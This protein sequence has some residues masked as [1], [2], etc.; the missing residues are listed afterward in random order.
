[1]TYHMKEYFV[2]FLKKGPNRDKMDPKE[3]EALQAQHLE[4][5]GNLHKEGKIIINGPFGDDGDLRG[6][7]F[8]SVASLEEAKKLASA[9]PMVQAGWLAVEVHPWFGAKGSTLD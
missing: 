2:V 1:M 6:M 3:A 4:Y 8:Y 7:S 5:L 9:D